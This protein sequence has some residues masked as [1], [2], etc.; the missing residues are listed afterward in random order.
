MT[1][2]EAVLNLTNAIL[3]AMIR[4]AAQQLVTQVTSS[5]GSWWSAIASAFSGAGGHATGGQFVDQAQAHPIPF[6]PAFPDGEWVIQA[7]AVSH[8]GH[9][10]M[11]A[12]N[13]KRLR[14]LATGEPVSVPPVPSY[15]EPGLSDSLRDGRA[16]ARTLTSPVNIQQTLAVDGA[17]L[18]TAG[19]KTT[20]G[21]KAVITM[22][23]ANKQT[24]KIF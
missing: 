14:K 7:S 24:V 11:D 2:R 16:G 23:R 6:P 8:Y 12:I 18:F 3:D 21:V 13:N 17:G 4:I 10:F 5:A 20:A 9:A 1:L 19:L 22:L 15:S